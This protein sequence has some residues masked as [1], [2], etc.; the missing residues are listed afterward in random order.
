MSRNPYTAEELSTV[1]SWYGRMST[2]RLAKKLN[3]SVQSVRVIASRHRIRIE[4]S[5]MTWERFEELFGITADAIKY[6]IRNASKGDDVMPHDRSGR[7]YIFYEDEVI[8]W[9]RRGNILTFDRALLHRD[10]QRIYDA[11]RRLY[12]TYN[13]IYAI[14]TAIVPYYCYGVRPVICAGNRSAYYRREDIWALWWLHGHRM[15]KTS[16]PYAEAV[17]IAWESS[18]V[19]KAEIQQLFNRSA[20]T[21]IA[22]QCPGATFKAVPKVELRQYFDRVGRHDLA[23]RYAER[24]MHYMELINELEGTKRR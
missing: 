1:R 21:K 6:R 4:R 23:K 5:R 22:Q 2:P 14:D 24:P 15:P 16:H 9:L 7:F 20:M 19:R 10:L 3:R 13:E 11:Q 17:R 8:E 12:Y 18:F